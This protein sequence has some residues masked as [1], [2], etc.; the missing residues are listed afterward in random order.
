MSIADKLQDLVTAKEDMKTALIE[1]GVTPG[2]LS[3]YADCI[4]GINTGEISSEI[5]F[6]YSD[7]KEIPWFDTS[8]RT[9][10]NSLF[11]ECHNLETI[12]PLN[13]QAAQ[14]MSGMFVNCIS[15]KSVPLLNCN[16]VLRITGLFGFRDNP[17]LTD[18]GGFQNF[19][20]MPEMVS[21]SGFFLDFTL[22]P[23][24]T[25]ESLMN[26]INNLFDRASVG[27]STI[28]LK[29]GNVNIAKL[30]EAEIAVCTNKGYLLID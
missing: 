13:T 19:G 25:H 7:F 11:Y 9:D 3:T 6:G 26:V 21:I 17:N 14:D 30:S 20:R 16:N 23:N 24:L 5:R 27:Y 2:G 12:P 10:F 4:R 8:S 15:L 29:F 1:K 18:L 22:L 28:S